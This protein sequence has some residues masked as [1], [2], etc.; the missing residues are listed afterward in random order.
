[1]EHIQLFESF[2]AKPNFVMGQFTIEDGPAHPAI[3][4]VETLAK[5]TIDTLPPYWLAP[6]SGSGYTI[7]DISDVFGKKFYSYK[8][9]PDSGNEGK[10]FE[11][12]NSV[13]LPEALVCILN[14][15][16]EVVPIPLNSAKELIA[17]MRGEYLD[18]DDI[19]WGAKTKIYDYIRDELE[20]LVVAKSNI[21]RPFNLDDARIIYVKL[22]PEPN[23]V[24]FSKDCMTGHLY[25]Q[26]E[27]EEIQF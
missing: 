4:E 17:L 27:I 9:G 1:M 20:P 7:L 5:R 12:S 13:E 19:R 14:D 16:F 18:V 23:T 15:M 24:F 10:F 21:V 6:S 3:F 25:W 26:P 22:Y 8:S 2:G 11:T